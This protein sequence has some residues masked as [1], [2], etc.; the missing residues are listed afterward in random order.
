[1]YSNDTQLEIL[2]SIIIRGKDILLNY[3]LVQDS[4]NACK[5]GYKCSYTVCTCSLAIPDDRSPAHS[6]ASPAPGIIAG[7]KMVHNTVIL[8]AIDYKQECI[9]MKLPLLLLRTGFGCKNI[10]IASF[11]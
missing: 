1:M 2:Y 8:T 10:R 11:L 9:Y 3:Q 5:M 7:N 6:A 4:M